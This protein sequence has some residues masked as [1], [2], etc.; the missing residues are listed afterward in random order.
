MQPARIFSSEDLRPF[1]LQ[2]FV[3]PERGFITIKSHDG[4][5][6]KI[7]EWPGLWNG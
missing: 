7:L 3:D 2:R 4:R 1:D 6:L 5:D